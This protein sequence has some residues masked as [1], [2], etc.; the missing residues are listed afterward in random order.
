[1]FYDKIQNKTNSTIFATFMT[2]FISATW[3]GIYLTYYI[4]NYYI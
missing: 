1:M 4:G 2:F 3:H